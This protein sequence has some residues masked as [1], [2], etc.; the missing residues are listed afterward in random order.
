MSVL[1]ALIAKRAR[2]ALAV[3]ALLQFIVFVRRPPAP[4]QLDRP[5]PDRP[6]PD[7][8]APERVA[9]APA[10]PAPAAPDPIAQVVAE[11]SSAVVTVSSPFGRQSQW[12]TSPAPKVASGTEPGHATRAIWVGLHHRSVRLHRHQ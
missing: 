6:S 10:T 3:V 1:D 9:S 12:T 7:R 11:V 4:R 2:H 5:S 8:P